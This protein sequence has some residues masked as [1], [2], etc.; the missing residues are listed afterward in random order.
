LSQWDKKEHAEKK[1]NRSGYVAS[2]NKLNIS[3]ELVSLQRLIVPEIVPLI[4]MRYNI[5]STIKSEGPIGRRNLAFVLDMSE[6]QVRNEIDFLQKQKL[7][8]VER[9]GVVL[10]DEGIQVIVELKQMLYTYNGLEQLERQLE[11]QLNLKRAIVSPGDVNLNYQVLKFMG[12]SAAQ[13]ILS[14]LKYKDVLALTG[15]ESTAT[16]AEQ[17][18]EA[19]YPDVY[20]IPARGGIGKSHST[21]ANNIVAEMGL[22]LHSN[23]ELLHLPDNIDSR[24][25]EALKDYPEIKRV[26]NKMED[27]DIFVFGIG[28]AEVLADWRFM[29]ENEKKKILA[30]GAIGEAFGHYFNIE[31]KAISPSS[32]IG[33]DLENYDR[34]PNRI[35][36]AGGSNK[37]KAIISV[38]RVKEDLVLI[39]DESAA[40]EIIRQL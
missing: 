22:K 39:T 13:Y 35:A 31:G 8:C 28:Q 30:E 7:I 33:I 1:E 17:M 3:E 2:N 32:T 36:I 38:S 25:L 16:V 20:V 6:R 10:T 24:L 37:A 21:Q 29:S 34:I 11:E 9:Q 15:G 12:N 14:M 19:F 27:I 5:L 26:F 18:Q 23:Y 40:K 4:E